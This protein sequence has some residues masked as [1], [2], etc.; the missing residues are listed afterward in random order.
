M[1]RQEMAS[2]SQLDESNFAREFAEGY[3]NPT[4]SHPC[5]VVYGAVEG[6]EALHASA[7]R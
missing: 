1:L 4:A 3:G 6:A 2:A 7:R 5:G